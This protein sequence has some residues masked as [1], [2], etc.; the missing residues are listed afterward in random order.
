[1]KTS[2]KKQLKGWDNT[3]EP[4]NLK[5]NV[6]A[7]LAENDFRQEDIE[8]IEEDATFADFKTCIDGKNEHGMNIIDTNKMI[9]FCDIYYIDSFL[10]D[11]IFDAIDAIA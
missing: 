1:M 9:R 7:W 6:R 2:T 10:R 11:A 3:Y 8:C 4:K 5:I